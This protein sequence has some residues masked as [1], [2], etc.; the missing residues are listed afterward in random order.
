[1]LRSS[2]SS[3]PSLVPTHASPKLV[4]LPFLRMVPLRRLRHARRGNRKRGGRK[5]TRAFSPAKR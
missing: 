1:M 3:N 2:M 5:A 4:A